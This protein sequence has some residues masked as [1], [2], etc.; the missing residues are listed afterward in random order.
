M[1][2]D[3]QDA[4]TKGICS[5]AQRFFGALD[6]QESTMINFVLDQYGSYLDALDQVARTDRLQRP[7]PFSGVRADGRIATPIAPSP[8]G[9]MVEV[10]VRWTGGPTPQ[11]RSADRT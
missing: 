6:D 9:D 4:Y 11:P 2:A 3:V 10:R 7:Q 8:T 1:R 5:G